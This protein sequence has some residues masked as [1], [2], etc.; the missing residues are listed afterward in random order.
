MPR[1]IH[2]LQCNKLLHNL[3]Q[4]HLRANRH[5]RY[6]PDKYPHKTHSYF[7]LKLLF[8]FLE[9]PELHPYQLT[10]T[11]H[12]SPIASSSLFPL[13]SPFPLTFFIRYMA[14]QNIVVIT[15]DHKSVFT[16]DEI[17]AALWLNDTGGL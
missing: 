10:L 4:R 12:C 7:Y 11:L 17:L 15:Q 3:A 14:A 1:I 5:S 16:T 9:S 2:Y 8:I 13:E 6:C